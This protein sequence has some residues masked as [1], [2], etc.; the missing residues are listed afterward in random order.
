[1]DV[2]L[3]KL[4]ADVPRIV[5]YVLLRTPLL[6]SIHASDRVT[7]QYQPVTTDCT[8]VW[9]NNTPSPKRPIK[10]QAYPC[11]MHSISLAFES[12]NLVQQGPC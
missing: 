7:S 10:R 1:V 12:K 11:S 8:V 9:T 4:K 5:I 3:V 2:D 6:R